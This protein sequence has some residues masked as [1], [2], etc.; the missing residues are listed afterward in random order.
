MNEFNPIRTL[1]HPLWWLMLLTLAVND[2]FFKSSAILPGEIT[3]KL[4][5]F[6]GL[7]VFPLLVA[8]CF[9]SPK[10]RTWLAIHVATALGFCAIKLEPAVGGIYVSALNA[11]GLTGQIW[12]DP[13]DLIALSVLPISYFVY[14]A[15]GLRAVKRPVS[16]FARVFA[17][18]LAGFFCVASGSAKAPRTLTQYD[19]NLMR[20]DLTF[21]NGTNEETKVQVERLNADVVFDCNNLDAIETLEKSQFTSLGTWTQIPGEATS[22]L[23][24][25]TRDQRTCQV[26]RLTVDEVESVLVIW[27]TQKV[28]MRDVPIQ[29][30]APMTPENMIDNAIILHKNKS[31]YYLLA[32]GNFVLTYWRAE[33][34]AIDYWKM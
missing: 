1:R 30:D 25:D 31:D 26:V 9:K 5:D 4:S 19:G 12:Y 8:L 27:D 23:P 10:R 32:K 6:A 34:F 18:A 33:R 20:S 17:V 15:L 21:I 7:M 22:L 13:T 14:P 11:M 3:G 2:F 24:A 29:F 28:P 16:S